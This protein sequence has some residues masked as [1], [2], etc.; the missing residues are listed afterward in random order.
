VVPFRLRPHGPAEFAIL[1][2]NLILLSRHATPR[3]VL[4]ILLPAF[5][6]AALARGSGLGRGLGAAALVI[7][8][9]AV[10]LG[11]SIARNDL[12]NDMTR[13]SV[14]KAWPVGGATLIRGELLAPA[15]V[16][17]GISWTALALGM[18]LFELEGLDTLSAL[19]R[20]W[21]G[22][23]AAI[24]A[25]PLAVAQ[26]VIQNGAVVLFPG[27]I[28]TGPTRPR[29]LEALGQQLLMLFGTAVVLVLGVLPAAVVA[30]LAALLLYLA[31]GYAGLVPASL[32]FSAVLAAEAL[33]GTHLL[34]R[35][36]DRTDPSHVE[37]AEG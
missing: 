27:W 7:S 1:W 13:L 6:M 31:I 2:K 4:W 34:G 14:L 37:A 25:P 3:V 20:L 36:L 9:I 16:I 26:L 15:V 30:G 32:L 5:T 18:T 29:G 22:V 33:A 23:A 11:P 19:D 28:P 10:L 12:R 24:A 21:L 35:V 8:G 17:T